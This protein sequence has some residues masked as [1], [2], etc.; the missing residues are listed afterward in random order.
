MMNA[1]EEN[2][3]VTVPQMIKSDASLYCDDVDIRFSKTMNSCKVLQIRYASVER[4]L[5]RLTDLRFLSIDFLNTFLHSY[6]VFT[7]ALVVLDK[8]ITIYKK[9]ISA[10]PARSLELL[11]ANSQNNK[12]LYG[13]PPK[14]PRANRKFSSPPPLSISK[15]SSPSRRRKL[16]LN[17][18]II[19]GGKAL[20]LAAL[21]CSSNGYAGV[22][23]SVAPFSKTTLD[24]NKLYVSSTYPNKIP[25][26]G[27]A[28]SE[29]QE[30]SLP[31]KQSES[32]RARGWGA[33]AQRGQFRCTH[34]E[35]LPPES[36]VIFNNKTKN[37][38]QPSPPHLKGKS[39][40][41]ISHRNS[42]PFLCMMAA[43]KA[44][45]GQ[46]SGK[47]G[48]RVAVF[49]CSGCKRVP[50]SSQ[51]QR[52]LSGRSQ[53]QIPTT[54]MKQKLKLPQRNLR[55]LPSPSSAKIHQVTSEVWG[56]WCVGGLARV[57]S[58]P[59]SSGAHGVLDFFSPRF[60]AVLLQQRHGH[61]VLPGPG[62]RPQ[63]RV[64]HLRLRHRHGGGQRG[65][66]HQGEIPQDVPG[67]RRYLPEAV[68]LG[69]PFPP[70]QEGI[71]SRCT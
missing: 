42:V 45:M 63:R 33:L 71:P 43:S 15:S 9:P 27:E 35:L 10:I 68:P 28:A 36:S 2:S 16:S 51:A 37:T 1:F 50:C 64:R 61:D 6:R 11:F 48:G 12:L 65:H 58:S 34:R 44:G 32:L 53:T 59:G 55:R 26:E 62:Q 39:C 7:T 69:C 30:E 8:L 22:Y 67:Q 19:T 41:K 23:S 66:P 5:E 38:S 21:S 54:A 56:C 47:W 20:D 49:V 13:E 25:D 14:S 18:P 4:L 24:I 3:K 70:F 40:P 57:G 46:T 29:K 52:C 31:G 60:L 17:I